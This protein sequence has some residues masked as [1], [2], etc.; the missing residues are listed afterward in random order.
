MST[1]TKN[2]TTLNEIILWKYAFLF[3]LVKYNKE[4]YIFTLFFFTKTF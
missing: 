2:Q 4:L 1:Q 3:K